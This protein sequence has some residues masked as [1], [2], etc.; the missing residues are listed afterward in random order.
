M[1]VQVDNT[2]DKNEPR[3]GNLWKW[4]D[5][6]GR[7]M[8]AWA[9]ILNR[10]TAL[11]L[12]LYL[13][14]HLVVLGQLALGPEYYNRFLQLLHNP[15]VVAAELL[16]VIAGIYHGLNGIRIALVSFGVAVPNQKLLFW[17]V[18]ALT[19]VGS[20]FFAIRMFGG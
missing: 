16:V 20:V 6:R 10:I 17:V 11:G 7:D 9:F 15:V 3:S 5:P 12:T 4:F 18:M 13:F 1:T 19:I 2:R 8:G 14:L